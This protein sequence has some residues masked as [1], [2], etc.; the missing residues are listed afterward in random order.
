MP[1]PLGL[2]QVPQVFDRIDEWLEENQEGLVG[3]A[4]AIA[5]I[6]VVAA[7]INILLRRAITRGM[8]RLVA[9]GRRPRLGDHGPAIIDPVAALA[10]ERRLQRTQALGTV[11]RSAVTVAV[12]LIAFFMIIGEL[13]ANLGPI[14]A[15]AGILGAALGFGAQNMVRDFLAGI[16]VIVEDQ[17]G[18]GD[19]I[20]AGHAVGTVEEVGL[21]TTRLRDSDGV[22][23]YVRN[24]EMVRVGNKTQGWAVANVDLQV[25]ADQDF[26]SVRS[27][28]E[29]VSTELAADE[30][31]REKLVEAPT[32][33]GIESMTGDSV[34]IRILIRTAPLVHVDV[35]RELRA[36]LK[37][38]FDAEGIRLR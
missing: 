25:P 6:L 14:L 26:D 30:R 13:G 22:I 35:A 2:L 36:R 31:W 5:V 10:G 17:Y 23:W 20:D 4:L 29:R 27:I 33:L 7:A 19:V 12:F 21:R 8:N 15:S 11:L 38:A 9:T 32:V 28:I 24:G 1:V 34:V 18:V 16:F 3:T 37:R